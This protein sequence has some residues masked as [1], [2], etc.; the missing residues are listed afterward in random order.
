MDAHFSAFL[1]I[2]QGWRERQFN[3]MIDSCPALLRLAG[4]GP[5]D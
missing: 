3:V 2:R 1:L 5:Q 4:S